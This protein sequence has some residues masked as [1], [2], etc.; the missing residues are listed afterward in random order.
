VLDPAL[1]NALARHGAE[2]ATFLTRNQHQILSH[3]QGHDHYLVVSVPETEAAGAGQLHVPDGEIYARRES[4]EISRLPTPAAAC[5]GICPAVRIPGPQ[6]A[7]P[8][9]ARGVGELRRPT[10]LRPSAWPRPPPHRFRRPPAPHGSV[11]PPACQTCKEQIQQAQGVGWLRR[12]TAP[13]P[14]VC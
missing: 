10:A 13:I 14:S 5:A 3:R 4:E 2:L 7:A 9:E 6:R 11:R 1:L 8:A 12:P